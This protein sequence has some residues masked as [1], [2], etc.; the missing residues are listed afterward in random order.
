MLEHY[1]YDPFGRTRNLDGSD[2]AQATS[3]TAPSMRRGFTGHEML[4][5]YIGGLIHMNGRIYDPSLGRFM[6]T[7]PHIQA[8]GYS[9][10]YNQYSYILNNPLG[11]TDPSGYLFAELAGLGLLAGSTGGGW[12]N[13]LGQQSRDLFSR[14]R[15][16]TAH[17]DTLTRIN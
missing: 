16:R 17:A 9:Q 2:I 4:T 11:G 6:T 3:M 15:V 10:S 1:S 8:A 5:E 12:A 13:P 14:R 7:D